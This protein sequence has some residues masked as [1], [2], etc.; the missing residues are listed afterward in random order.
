M[1]PTPP[2]SLLPAPTTTTSR[3]HSRIVFQSS[4][5]RDT[6]AVDAVAGVDGAGAARRRRKRRLRSMLRHERQTVAMEV[7]AALHQGQKAASSPGGRPDVLAEQ[8]R[9]EGVAVPAGAPGLAL[10]T[11]AVAAS[12]V[13][14]SS[15]LR[16][17][18]ASALEAK[19][20]EEVAREEKAVAVLGVF[21]W[22][23]G[24]RPMADL[25][26]TSAARDRQLRSWLRR[27]DDRADRTGGGSASQLWTP[28]QHRR[29]TAIF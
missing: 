13:V 19:R 17:L 11:V 22:N 29:P 2:S 4:L 24:G 7:T 1:L 20:K 27:A 14:D 28:V 10:P 9:T 5:S 6:L 26:G 8:G 12:E 16:F 18:T 3:F 15:T 25:A 21:L 23:A